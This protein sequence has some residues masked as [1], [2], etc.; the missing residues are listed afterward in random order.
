MDLQ[1]SDRLFI[2]CGASDGLGRGI[3]QA[4]LAEGARVLAVGRSPEK[5]AALAGDSSDRCQT[6]ALD[7]TADDGPAQVLAALAGKAPSGVVLN[8]GG[9]PVGLAAETTGAE[10][11]A[12][13]RLVFR[14]K[15]E[16]VTGLLPAMRKATPGRILFVESQGV[17]QPIPGLAQSNAMR[18]AVVGYAKTLSQELATTG[19]TVNVLAPGAHDTAALERVTQARQQ[20]WE[21]D[22]DATRERMQA[23]IPVGRFGAA[24]EFGCLA[25]WLLS[26]HSGYITGQVISHDGGNIQGLF[27]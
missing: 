11:D 9:P 22:R 5:L 8:A 2:V 18:S 14:W 12:A 3:C 16:L 20:A 7:L 19:I 23:A 24:E 6:L 26:P 15:A 25:A 17:K 13:Y 21:L 4:L 27:G 1:L 10:W